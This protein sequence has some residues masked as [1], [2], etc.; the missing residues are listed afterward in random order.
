MVRRWGAV[1]EAKGRG[2]NQ[3]QGDRGP[4]RAMPGGARVDIWQ[5]SATLLEFPEAPP[6]SPPLS[7]HCLVTS[8]PH[9]VSRWP[10]AS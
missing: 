3:S 5:E 8:H 1:R 2:A 7:P 4:S 9:Q 10:Y 6:C